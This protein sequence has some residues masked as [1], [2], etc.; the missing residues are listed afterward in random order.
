MV[1]APLWPFLFLWT[2]WFWY[3]PSP[4]VL[5]GRLPQQRAARYG[6]AASWFSIIIFIAILILGIYDPLWFWFFLYVFLPYILILSMCGAIP[7]FYFD[8]EVKEK[9]EQPMR[10]QTSTEAKQ[11]QLRSLRMQL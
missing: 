11:P 6:G 2:P 1:R 8:D 7:L 9:K 4:Y 5:N 10:V 3:Y